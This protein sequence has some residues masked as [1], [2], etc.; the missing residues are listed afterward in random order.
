MFFLLQKLRD[1]HNMFV[2]QQILKD[3]LNNSKHDY[4]EIHLIDFKDPEGG[5]LWP[6]CFP[7]KYK[8]AIPLGTIAFVNTFLKIFKKINKMNPIEIPTC[9][10]NQYFLKRDYK[11]YFG[12]E[13]PNDKHYFIKDASQLKTL[14]HI[15]HITDIEHEINPE[16]VYQVSDILNIIGV[17]FYNH[18]DRDKCYTMTKEETVDKTFDKLYVNAMKREVYKEF[19][20][21]NLKFKGRAYDSNYYQDVINKFIEEK[22]RSEVTDFE[23]IFPCKGNITFYSKF[24]LNGNNGNSFTNDDTIVIWQYL[25]TH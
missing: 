13:I 17:K 5:L 1:D 6:S 4:E 16:H 14:M 21:D 7:D 8:E 3:L 18:Y 11:F 15:G 20:K 24:I 25:L 23:M 12:N 9:L 22:C 19:N 10:R 2:D